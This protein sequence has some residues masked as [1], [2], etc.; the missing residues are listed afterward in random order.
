[1]REYTN[2]WTLFLNAE[3]A[4]EIVQG[5]LPKWDVWSAATDRLVCEVVR[6]LE[7]GAFSQLSASRPSQYNDDLIMNVKYGD[8]GRFKFSFPVL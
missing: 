3:A 8:G 2:G 6:A 4:R 1:M 5:S 7:H